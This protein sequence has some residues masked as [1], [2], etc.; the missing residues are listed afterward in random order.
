IADR[1]PIGVED[2][3]PAV[4]VLVGLIVL[5]KPVV[6]V[7]VQHDAVAAIGPGTVVANGD[8]V[9]TAGSDDPVV[10]APD[11]AIVMDIVA[12]NDHVIG[13]VVGIEAIAGVVIH[14]VVDPLTAI[15]AEGVGAPE[16]VVNR[17]EERRV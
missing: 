14:F 4:P 7:P 1:R 2:G 12:F 9:A 8:V 13:V 5:D 3:D 16:I 15:S 6:T 10:T 11:H 17:S